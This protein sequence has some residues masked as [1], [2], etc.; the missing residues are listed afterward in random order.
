[1][2]TYVLLAVGVM[3][4]VAVLAAAGVFRSAS[5]RRVVRRPARRV[6]EQPVVEERVEREL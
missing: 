3:L 6:V 5:S 1:M 4:A 2:W